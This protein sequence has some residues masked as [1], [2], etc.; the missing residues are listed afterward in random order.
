MP[1]KK[2]NKNH[3]EE[4]NILEYVVFYCSLALIITLLAYLV[5]GTV[6]IEESVPNLKVEYRAQPQHN[7]P[8][9]FKI[10]INNSG[11]RTAED[12]LV[13]MI[14]EI[15]GKEIE[16]SQLQMMFVPGNTNV[17]GWIN[18]T[19]DPEKADTVYARIVSYKSS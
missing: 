10:D 13:E 8:Y 7:S 14:Q 9:L 15:D 2:D 17:D 11:S 5:Y 18:F 16:K 1:N 3:K 19:K 4:K 12:V 6:T